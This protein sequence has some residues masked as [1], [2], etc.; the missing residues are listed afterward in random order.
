MRGV[1]FPLTHTLAT[2]VASL[3]ADISVTFASPER[4]AIDPIEIKVPTATKV[5]TD[6]IV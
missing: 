4:A 3:Y 5:S 6:T 1:C 2:I